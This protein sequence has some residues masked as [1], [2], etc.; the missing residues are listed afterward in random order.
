M[1]TRPLSEA[2]YTLFPA[3]GSIPQDE[4][5]ALVR[6]IQAHLPGVA[7]GV[8]TA[9]TCKGYLEHIPYEET[10]SSI[11]DCCNVVNGCL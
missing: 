1:L 6:R 4:V 8:M 7:V 9:T 11:A 2:E 10:R 5:L 3:D